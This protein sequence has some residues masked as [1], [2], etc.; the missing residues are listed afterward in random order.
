MVTIRDIEEAVRKLS[1]SELLEFRRWFAEF[2]AAAWDAQFEADARS[3]R[4]D[5]LAAEALEDLRQ[6]RTSEL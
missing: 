4:L 1:P 3:G 6:G 5:H 2:D